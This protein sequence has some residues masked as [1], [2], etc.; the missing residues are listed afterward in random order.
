MRQPD[1]ILYN[2]TIH[3]MDPAQPQADAIAI[4]R[5]RVLAIGSRDDLVSSLGGAQSLDLCG[6]TV[7]PGMIDSHIHFLSY[8]LGLSRIDLHEVPTL[9]EAQ[10]RIASGVSRATPG[11]WIRG[12]GWNHNLWAGAGFPHRRDLDAISPANPVALSSKDGHAV[13][14]NTRA[15]E[16]AHITAQTPDPPGGHIRRDPSGE[17]SGILL[18]N[19]TDLVY[20]LVPPP[21][22]DESKAACRRGMHD[23]NRVGL[24]GI[25][26]C[27]DELALGALQQL[28]QQG[29]LSLRV[30]MHVP[31]EH[32]DAAIALGLRDGL[33]DEW[34]RIHG[35][36]A[37]TDGA[38]GPRSAWM[39]SPFETDA[40]N[41]G[42]PT[43]EPE[44]LRDLV[45]RANSAGLSVAIHAIGDAANRA[46]LDAIASVRQASGA[47]LRNRI[48]HV[49]LLH[50]A[51]VPRLAQLGVIASMQPIH[52]T[53]DMLIA[54]LHWGKRAATSYAWRSLLDAGT[55]LA[56]GSDAPVEDPSP[57]LGIHAAVTRRRPAGS[58]G[59]QGWYPEQR[60][61]ARE[62][63]YA[64]TVG[65]AYAGGEEKEKGSLM[66]GKLA[67]LVILDRDIMVVDP[68]DILN[69]RVLGTMV[70]GRFVYRDSGL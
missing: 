23:L 64:Y 20:D 36:K 14:I 54:D 50:P 35:V 29:E 38:L 26:D 21:S 63:V 65:A 28:R 15:M 66:P 2:G 49:Q 3:T 58:P 27:E 32:L 46:V 10:Q 34:V 7:I 8:S 68:M 47:D 57:L 40:A 5:D 18:E 30:T 33:G 55:H 45:G 41:T 52:A 11:A 62:A 42:I 39:L 4:D 6:S 37:F 61:S 67:D 48:E 59:P 53:S 25:H 22:L 70:G 56:F 69:T 24:T 9:Q 43:L 31:A 13:W 1:W 16:L 44:A 19:A 17:P 51:D 60:I 12:A